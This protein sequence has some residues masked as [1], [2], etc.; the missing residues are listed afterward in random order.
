MPSRVP[1]SAVELNATGE[2]FVRGFG[3]EAHAGY[4]FQAAQATEVVLAAIARSD[5]TRA[6]VL[7]ELR[8]ARPRRADR[9]LPLRPPTGT[10]RR[11]GSRSCA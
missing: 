11:P 3:E 6:S 5:G 7:R 2:R 8:D 9:R 4:V 1:P 10:S